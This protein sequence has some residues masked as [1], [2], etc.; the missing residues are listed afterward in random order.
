MNDLEA[1]QGPLTMP[2]GL[3]A[4]AAPAGT[5]GSR[6]GRAGVPPSAS[7]PCPAE[8]QCVCWSMLASPCVCESSASTAEAPMPGSGLGCARS[9]PGMS[10]A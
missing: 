2:C 5:A 6:S 4:Y 1:A 7:I 3:C 9:Q 10:A 8:R